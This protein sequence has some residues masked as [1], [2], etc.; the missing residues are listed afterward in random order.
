MNATRDRSTRAITTARRRSRAVLIAGSIFALSAVLAIT[1]SAARAG[2]AR[3]VVQSSPLAGFRHYEAPNLWAEIKLGDP[4]SLVRE[5]A[6]AHDGN[7]VRVDWRGATLGYI[8]RSQNAAVAR[9]LDSGSALRARITKI[10]H[11]RAPNQR[12]EFEVYLPQ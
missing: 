11:T 3:I 10:Q 5:P 4:L 9:Q 7:A 8:P 1:L 2:E 12:I 6:N